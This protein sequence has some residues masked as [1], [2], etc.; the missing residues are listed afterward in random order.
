MGVSLTYTLHNMKRAKL[1]TENTARASF[2]ENLSDSGL[3]VS[4]RILIA[5]NLKIM[6]SSALTLQFK[7]LGLG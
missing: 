7:L 2:W 3:A 4:Q 1:F 5:I 6:L